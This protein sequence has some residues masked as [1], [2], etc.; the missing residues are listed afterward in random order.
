M[1][2]RRKG[3]L[4]AVACL[5]AAPPVRASWAPLGSP[6]PPLIEL[7]LETS[8]PELLYARVAAN[9]DGTAGYLWRS[10]DAG[11]T[12]RD[13]QSGLDRPFAALAIDPEDPRVIWVWTADGE[14]WRSPDAGDTWA[15]R[16]A[17]ANPI[18]STVIQLLVDPHH[19]NTLY[20]VEFT[21]TRRIVAVSRDGGA[22]FTAGAPLRTF[23]TANPLAVNP[24]RNEL[25]AFDDRGAQVSADGGAT[26]TTRGNFRRA[27]FLT[28]RVAPSDP[29]TQYAV[30]LL[31]NQ[32]LARSDD[33]GAHWQK[34]AYPPHLPGA[35]S[36]CTGVAVDP[37]N[38]LHVWVTANVTTGDLRNNRT[39][40]SR[41]G[42]I[43]WGRPFPL[44]ADG[45]VAAGGGL[46]YTGGL[47][48][49]GLDVSRNGGHTWVPTDRGIL[50]GDLRHGVVAQRI[51]GGGPGR[52]LLVLDSPLTGIA[53][54]LFRSD[55]GQSWV[56]LPFEAVAIA[57]AGG[58]HVVEADASGVQWS[59]DGGETWTAATS[60]PPDALGLRT[61]LLQPRYLALLASE[62][63]GPYGN[64]AVWLSDD[65][66]VSWNRRSEGLPVA[67][68]HV[69]DQDEC[70]LFEAYA[71]DPYNPQ[72]RWLTTRYR[73]APTHPVLYTSADGGASW[74]PESADLP[75]THALA[76]NPSFPGH[77]FAGTEGG[78]FASG[79]GGATW[80]P[81]G[82]LPAAADV[83][84]FARDGATWYAATAAS[85]IF[86]SLDGGSHWT[87]LAGAPDRDN[88][89]IA[90]DPRRPT[91]LLAAFAG[92]GL[93][94]WTP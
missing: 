62:D 70:P 52:R 19:P 87:L 50:A 11:A 5:L 32:C 58:S 8:R 71:V 65:A 55:G 60:A 20:R 74:Q 25:I 30:S 93:W 82:D 1:F 81:I 27:G 6:E 76:V 66:G 2:N 17:P 46:L 23:T 24:V 59:A 88:P 3:L 86:R 16:P 75:D 28:G 79:D 31:P 21:D 4:I 91:A 15:R 41:D 7:Q 37:Q 34:L 61:D 64:V 51:P 68:V 40:E 36:S 83:R 39:Y 73:H 56:S 67:C 12:W 89:T 48:G 53:D 78:L 43:T 94:R 90:V 42:G 26:W 54:Q 49:E 45:I 85:G 29:D 92:Q 14:L 33:D 47:V 84:Q 80:A 69:F 13:V 72:R 77:L 18:G 44:P 35:N 9:Q 10:T 57:N 38:A 22:S 63:V